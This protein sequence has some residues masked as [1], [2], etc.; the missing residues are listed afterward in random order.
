MDWH[1]R[2]PMDVRTISPELLRATIPEGIDLLLASPSM[3]AS[4][5]PMTHRERTPVGPKVVRHILHL[6]LYLSEAQPEGVGDLRNSSKLHPTS[7]N[8][9][10]LM[11]QGTL[12][13][14]SEYGSGAHRNTRIW[15][16]LMPHDILEA[17][18]ARLLPPNRPADAALEVAEL[19]SWSTFLTIEPGD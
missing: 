11:G 12:L 16:N 4:H 14:A 15:K 6:I 19:T 18:H 7:A 17:E 5:L 9:L 3:L 8:T 2:L 1:S 10:T 13:D